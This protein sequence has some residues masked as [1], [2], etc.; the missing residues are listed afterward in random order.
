MIISRE[1]NLPS[2]VRRDGIIERKIKYYQ[3]ADY[4]TIDEYGNI[5]NHKTQKYVTQTLDKHGYY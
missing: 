2:I 3:A 5:Y 1:A 4:Y